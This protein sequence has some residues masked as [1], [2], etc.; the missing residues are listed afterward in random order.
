MVKNIISITDGQL[1]LSPD[2]FAKGVLPAVDVGKSVSR[3]GGKAQKRA[4]RD[5]VGKLRLS[6]SQFEEL[7]TFARFAT[8]LDETTKGSIERGK[9]LRELLRQKRYSPL[10]DYEQIAVLFALNAGLLD[11]I[12]VKKI[13]EAEQILAQ[14]VGA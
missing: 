11:T 8:R 5:L 4:Y 1:Y 10:E 9:R 14:Q 3:V 13:K 2:L 12:E 6:Y 7:E